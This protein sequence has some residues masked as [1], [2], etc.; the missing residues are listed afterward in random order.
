MVL[1]RRPSYRVAFAVFWL[2][3]VIMVSL[4]DHNLPG[5]TWIWAERDLWS[6][7]NRWHSCKPSF[8]NE[9]R[10]YRIYTAV[11]PSGL[12]PRSK[13]PSSKRLDRF[14]CRQLTVFSSS[15]APRCPIFFSTYIMIKPFSRHTVRNVL[16][17]EKTFLCKII[18]ICIGEE[19]RHFRFTETRFKL[20][21]DYGRDIQGTAV[22]L[23]VKLIIIHRF[24]DGSTTYRC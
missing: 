15:T 4:A 20:A 8:K 6:R 17:S 23:F 9:D 21:E 14:G 18:I 11:A 7:H 19:I 10:G 2:A 22:I 24:W 12:I 16:C 3:V 13:W 1:R 5:N